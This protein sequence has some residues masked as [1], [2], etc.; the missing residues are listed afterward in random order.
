MTDLHEDLLEYEKARIQAETRRELA[1]AERAEAEA[2]RYRH[3][4]EMARL[5]LEEQARS[6]RELAA[7]DTNNRVYHFTEVVNGNTVRAAQAKLAMW[8]RLYPG[9]PFEIVFN[10]PGGSVFDGVALFDYIRHLSRQQHHITTVCR[11]VAASMGGI[12]LQAGDHRVMG[13]ESYLLIHEPS[14]IAFGKAGD[15][16][17]TQAMLDRICTQTTKIFVD[18]SG[19]KITAAEFKKKWKRTDWWVTAEEALKYGFTD[20]VS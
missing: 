2:A 6:Y 15:I 11:G 13:A 16:E 10:S 18:R 7:T 1:D 19:G 3:S 5:D 9:E 14:T 17:D 4:A 8:H 12:L 20:E